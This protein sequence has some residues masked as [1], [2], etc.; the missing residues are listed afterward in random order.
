[1]Y[2][3][4]R[5][6]AA[7]RGFSWTTP[8]LLHSICCHEAY[9][10]A[11]VRFEPFID[12][13][14]LLDA[15]TSCYQQPKNRCCMSLRL[16]ICT[17]YDTWSMLTVAGAGSSHLIIHGYSLLLAS[18]RTQA[19]QDV[20][21]RFQRSCHIAYDNIAVPAW[22]LASAAVPSGEKG[23]ETTAHLPGLQHHQLHDWYAFHA[24]PI[25]FFWS[26]SKHD[27]WNVGRELVEGLCT[28]FCPYL[29]VCAVSWRFT[30][31]DLSSAKH[32]GVTCPR[33]QA[34]C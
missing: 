16:D 29:C 10:N 28:R 17:P 8:A 11:S 19:L 27:W 31:R 23:K 1:M 15:W 14:K 3:R 4:E 32:S 22:Y 20:R 13:Q 26:W 18:A 7:K 9:R 6:C 24:R 25:R 2:V 34:P 21:H 12:L 33:E 5:L 30:S